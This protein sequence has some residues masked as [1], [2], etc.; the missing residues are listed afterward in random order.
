MKKQTITAEEYKKLIKKKSSAHAHSKAIHKLF[1]EQLKTLKENGIEYFPEYKFCERKWRFDFILGRRASIGDWVAMKV[2]HLMIAI[3]IQGA[4]WIQGGH[5]RGS[6]YMRDIEKHN[7]ATL[8]GW[9]ILKF[10]PEQVKNGEAIKF[11]K[12]LLK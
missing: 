10:T 12:R 8:L 9:R 1:E 7:E 6:G 3:E 11:I 2:E 5:S 4:I